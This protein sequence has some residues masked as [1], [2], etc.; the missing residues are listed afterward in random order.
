[1]ERVKKMKLKKVL[2]VVIA[3]VLCV[4]LF[5]GCSS[6]ADLKVY[7]GQFSEMWL[8][9]RF[10]KLLVEEH[11]DLK[12]EILDE[13]APLQSYNEM[14]KGNSDFMNSYD[15]TLLTTFLGLDAS[16]V[17]AGISLFDFVNE[18]AAKDTKNTVQLLDKLGINNTYILGV[19]QEIAEEYG[20]E[21][22]SDLAA[23][24]DKLVFGAEHDF[25]IERE[26]AKYDPLVE[27]YGLEFKE[28]RPMDITLKYS[29]VK[30]G[31][32]DVTLVYA[33][34]GR[35]KEAN[36]KLLK[37]DKQ[38]FPEYNGA[39]LVRGD[40]F[41]RFEKKAPNLREVFG[42]LN[43]LV[44]DEMMVELTYEIDINNRSVDEVAEEFLKQQGLI[45]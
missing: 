16:D 7:D 18:E 14:K 35:N 19:P 3:V 8:V 36:L 15:G 45:S 2:A 34:D 39:V 4:G 10:V 41:T 29:A 13:M 25:F 43:G 17:P 11:T 12:V 26:S 22:I 28:K 42:M 32:I 40:I 9:H 24:A 44:S 23:V 6:K 33:T 38:F 1:M 21:T 27:L 5:T 37:D 20:L 30:S 31:N